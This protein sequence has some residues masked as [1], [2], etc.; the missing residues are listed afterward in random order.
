MLKEIQIE[1]YVNLYKSVYNIKPRYINFNEITD[2]ELDVMIHD[3]S[4][5]NDIMLDGFC[6]SDIEHSFDLGAATRAQA[7]EWSKEM[8]NI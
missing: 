8:N 5:E 7:I 4:A 3:I 2:E 1:C 6:E